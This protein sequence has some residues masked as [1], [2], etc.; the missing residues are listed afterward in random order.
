[1]NLFL[2]L[3]AVTTRGFITGEMKRIASLVVKCFL[4]PALNMLTSRSV[5]KQG[6][7]VSISPHL[8]QCKP[9]FGR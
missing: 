7:C 9:F 8:G 6:D 1:M 4:T 3:P 2:V 5:R